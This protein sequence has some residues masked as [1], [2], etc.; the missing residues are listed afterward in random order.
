[1]EAE[2]IFDTLSQQ[3]ICDGKSDGVFLRGLGEIE[4]E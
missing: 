1:L 3:M 4:F 2:R